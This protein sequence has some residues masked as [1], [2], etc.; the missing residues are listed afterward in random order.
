MISLLLLNN[1][2][3]VISYWVQKESNELSYTVWSLV[4]VRNQLPLTS[5]A[6]MTCHARREFFVPNYIFLDLSIFKCNPGKTND[7]FITS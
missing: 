3:P 4:T 2:Y 1:F 7:K 5:C 6:G